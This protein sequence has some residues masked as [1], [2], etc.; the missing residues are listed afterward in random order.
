MAHLNTDER[1]VLVLH[2]WADLTLDAVAERLGWPV[3]TVKSRLHHGL[4]EIRR[5]L[6]AGP[7][8]GSRP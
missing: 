7:D 2:Y 6:D 5:A 1:V 4:R 8:G 3:G